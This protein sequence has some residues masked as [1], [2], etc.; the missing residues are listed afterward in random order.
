MIA[1]PVSLFYFLL[2]VFALFAVL[3]SVALLLAILLFWN[4]HRI[5]RMALAGIE[6]AQEK[7]AYVG[8]FLTLVTGL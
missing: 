6:E 4:L 2:V 3:V 7:L 1:V 5:S 8:S